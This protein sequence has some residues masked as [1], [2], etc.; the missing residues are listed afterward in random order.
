MGL[1]IKDYDIGQILTVLIFS[2][3]HKQLVALVEGG[4]VTHPDARNVAI[5][6]NQGPVEGFQV[7][8]E[9]VIVN[10]IRKLIKAAECVDLIVATI[11]D[12]GVDE[13]G[14]FLSRGFGYSGPISVGGA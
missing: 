13:T 5:I 10:F 11:C 9:D 7:E 1:Q 6:V 4:R 12:R 8:F 2:A 3:V 14:W